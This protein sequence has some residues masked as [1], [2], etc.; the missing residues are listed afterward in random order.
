MYYAV[1]G[2]TITVLVGII[3]SYMTASKDDTYDSKLLHPLM[4]R[5]SKWLPGKERHY[6]NAPE[7]SRRNTMEGKDIGDNCKDIQNDH[8]NFA[9]EL[10]SEKVQLPSPNSNSNTLKTKIKHTILYNNN[11]NNNNNL[12]DIIVL[13]TSDNL[14]IKNTPIQPHKTNE[15]YRRMSEDEILPR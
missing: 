11:I 4:L 2:T 7:I 15:V 3:V 1:F 10:H 13:N 6:V 12:N 5:F 8:D 9:F 14:S